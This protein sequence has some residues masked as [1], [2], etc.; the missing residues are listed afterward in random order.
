ML[1]KLKSTDFSAYIHQSFSI[2]L[3]S[4]DQET[5]F[6]PV[7][8]ELVEV[9]ELG[10]RQ[11]KGVKRDPFSVIFRCPDDTKMPQQIYL[12]EHDEL[13]LLTLFLVP[14]GPGKT[15]YLYEAIFS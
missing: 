14:V 13:G 6:G 10:S 9:N 11:K 2:K 12:V 15:G 4:T 5:V 7:E 3:V 8:A 1:D